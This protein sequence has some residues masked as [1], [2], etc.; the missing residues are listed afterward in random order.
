MRIAIVNDLSL[1]IESIRRTL[2]RD[3]THEVVWVAR[4][5]TEAIAKCAQDRP[6]LILMDLIMP[7]LDGVESTR[8]IMINTP[9]PILIVTAT[10]DGNSEKVFE[11]LGAG[12]LDVVQTPVLGA[13]HSSGP[14]VLLEKIETL[15]KR[16]PSRNDSKSFAVT[17][18][19]PGSVKSKQDRLVAIGASAGGPMAI[20]EVLGSLG[21]DF[22]AAIVVIQHL[23]PEFS[24]GMA[25]W[26]NQ[27]SL[28]PV[29]LA[30]EGDKPEMGTVFIAST[31]DHLALTDANT[32]CYTRN[33]V[34]YVYRPSID[35]FFQSVVK[36]WPGQAVGVLLTGMGHDGAQGLKML[37]EAGYFTIAQDR[38]SSAVYG[39][40]KAAAALDAA[41]EI[42]PLSEI[43]PALKKIYVPSFI[44]RRR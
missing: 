12:A 1:A 41:V 33:P 24:P 34:D 5:G 39:M 21:A 6:D 13:P 16:I 28:L 15:R 8:W 17:P 25:E 4:N 9:C 18:I 2:V 31:A 43:G 35:V 30:R 32:F 3:G 26:L 14:A 42:L 22:P 7:V 27:H 10:V 11:A 23:N 29:R 44:E 36:H 20:M 19:R 38:M 40:P 37:R